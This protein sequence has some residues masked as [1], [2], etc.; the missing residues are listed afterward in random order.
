MFEER[1]A[2]ESGRV[3]NIVFN[4]VRSIFLALMNDDTN[5]KLFKSAIVSRSRSQQLP[6][7]RRDD[8]ARLVDDLRGSNLLSTKDH[9]AV[10]PYLARHRS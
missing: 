9:C 1:I 4:R 7:I 6:R 5:A 10:K 3:V 2:D 8:I